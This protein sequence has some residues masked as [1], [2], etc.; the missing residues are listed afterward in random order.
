MAI[1]AMN[2]IEKQN[3]KTLKQKG[4]H[5]FWQYSN[6]EKTGSYWATHNLLICQYCIRTMAS[7][8]INDLELLPNL[9]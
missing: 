9:K 5:V 8:A 6:G 2:N 3:A 4:F 7:A 1:R